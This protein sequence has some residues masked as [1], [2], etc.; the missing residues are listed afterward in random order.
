MK[1]ITLKSYIQDKKDNFII[2]YRF[3]QYGVLGIISENVGKL[4]QKMA[5]EKQFYDFDEITIKIITE[6]K[7]SAIIIIK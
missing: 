4:K 2:D 1:E 6:N 7:D 3:A 5:I